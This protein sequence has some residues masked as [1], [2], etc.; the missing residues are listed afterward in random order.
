MVNIK[1]IA[2]VILVSALSIGGLHACIEERVPPKRPLDMDGADAS[3]DLVACG[4]DSPAILCDRQAGVCAGAQARCDPDAQASSVCL[5][6]V[7]LAHSPAYR[8][9]DREGWLCD[10]LDNDCDGQVDEACCQG[11]PFPTAHRWPLQT[12]PTSILPRQ[13]GDGY[14]A[15]ISQFARNPQGEPI[16][17]LK[18]ADLTLQGSPRGPSLTL[19]PSLSPESAFRSTMIRLADGRILV[20]Y[21]LEDR[22]GDGYHVLTLD[23]QGKREQP[24]TRLDKVTIG[25]KLNVAYRPSDDHVFFIWSISSA[26]VDRRTWLGCILPWQSLQDRC[27]AEAFTLVS[28]LDSPV[29]PSLLAT[30]DGQF[31]AAWPDPAARKLRWVSLSERPSSPSPQGLPTQEID[32]R[33]SPDGG[34]GVE[35]LPVGLSVQ[36]DELSLWYPEHGPAGAQIRRLIPGQPPQEVT[37]PVMGAS[38]FAPSAVPIGP[39]RH[40]VT[41]IRTEDGVNTVHV[42]N[43]ARGRVMSTPVFNRPF[44]PPMLAA[45][46]QGALLLLAELESSD[47]EK[48][49]ASTMLLSVQ[50]TPICSP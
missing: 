9:Q 23:A 26:M 28:D 3:A 35:Q 4:D 17:D 30:P 33:V 6:D 37:L 40:L 47:A 13:D 42:A 18:L 36:G 50:G 39:D 41:F 46:S 24:P 10:G 19:T 49:Q 48:I 44:L 45:A 34:L 2:C 12:F 43:F 25:D 7:Y 27:V 15:L 38:I 11:A 14:L 8:P 32:A 29:I 16:I 31:V 20:F 22:Q 21:V 5:P 1:N